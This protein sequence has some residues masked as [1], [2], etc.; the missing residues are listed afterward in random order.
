MALYTG[1]PHE[2]V[3]KLV[4]SIA[5]HNSVKRDVVKLVNGHISCAATGAMHVHMLDVVAGSCASNCDQLFEYLFGRSGRVYE[6]YPPHEIRDE[7]IWALR[8]SEGVNL[9]NF[10]M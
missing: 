8:N 2:S 4:L 10:V 5:N 3:D 9:R 1:V 7:I 6:S